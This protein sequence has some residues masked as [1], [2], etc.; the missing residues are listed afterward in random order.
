MKEFSQASLFLKPRA[1]DG[2]IH[3]LAKSKKERERER[4]GNRGRSGKIKQAISVIFTQRRIGLIRKFLSF[5]WL[6]RIENK[7]HDVFSCNVND[8]CGVS[9]SHT[10]EAHRH[11]S[12]SHKTRASSEHR[13]QSERDKEIKHESK[14]IVSL[15]TMDSAN[16]L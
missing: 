11:E 3:Y 12:H 1:P 5:K 16:I 13:E 9:V 7:L 15:N 8:H 14:G 6:K 10:S 4:E 2:A